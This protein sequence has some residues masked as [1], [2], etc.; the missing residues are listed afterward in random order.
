MGRVAAENV[1]GYD[2]GFYS[3]LELPLILQAQKLLLSRQS[4]F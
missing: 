2:E 4:W 3:Y 1:V